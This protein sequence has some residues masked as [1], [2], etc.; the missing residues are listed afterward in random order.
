[1][2]SFI[3]SSVQSHALAADCSEGG[4][5]GDDDFLPAF[6]SSMSSEAQYAGLAAYKVTVNGSVCGVE[7][8]YSGG[9]CRRRFPSVPPWCLA[10][11][12]V[13]HLISRTPHARTLVAHQRSRRSEA[14]LCDLVRKVRSFPLDLI[15][16]ILQRDSQSA[17]KI[18][19]LSPEL[20]V[21]Q[22]SAAHTQ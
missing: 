20:S 12:P 2:P 9:Y 13:H 11:L 1:M 15:Q 6:V 18:Q 4:D 3:S 8:M 10:R 22:S 21:C 5:D 19:S 7:H 14:N 16:R 17:L